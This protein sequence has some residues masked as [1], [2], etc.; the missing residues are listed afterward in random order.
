MLKSVPDELKARLQWVV[1]R[2]ERRDGKP[3]KVPYNP[4]TL[5]RADTTD[6]TTWSDFFTACVAFHSRPFSGLGYVFAA[7]DPYAG[8]DQDDCIDRETGEIASYA[9]ENVRLL[10]SYTEIS[11]SGTGLKT[12][13][14]ATKR[15]PRCTTSKGPKC[16]FYDR[17]RFFAVTGRV[18]AGVSSRVEARDAEYHALYTQT[19][20]DP[21]SV[22]TDT[23]SADAAPD[24]FASLDDAALL[25]LAFAA[26]NGDETRTLYNGSDLTFTSASEADASLLCRLA[27]YTQ[28][29]V[30]QGTAQLERLLRGSQRL[31][32]KWDEPRG[33]TTW[34]AEQIANGV[35]CVT[36]SY[37]PPRRQNQLQQPQNSPKS[38]VAAVANQDIPIAW[39]P[40]ISLQL[41][42]L[43]AFPTDALPGWLGEFV[44]G[45]AATTETAPDVAAMLAL[46]ICALASA[47]VA[48]IAAG[49]SWTEPL[50]LFTVVALPPASRKSAVFAFV[51]APL[52]AYEQRRNT[53]LTPQIA[54]ALTHLD[55]LNQRLKHAREEAVKAK[56]PLE[57]QK[58]EQEAMALTEEVRQFTESLPV[59]LRL[60]ADDCTPEKLVRLM[61]EQGGHMGLLSP[62]GG[63]FDIM[64]GRY[65][66]KGANLDIYLKGHAGDDYHY[67]RVGGGSLTLRA[68]TLTMGLAVQPEVLRGLMEKP[69]FRG[70]GLLG[71]FL[72][73]LPPDNIGYCHNRDIPLPETLAERY[74]AGVH[75]L[76]DLTPEPLGDG[77]TRP[78]LLQMEPE[79]RERFQAYRNVVERE[80]RAGEE[81]GDITDWGGKLRG[82]IARIAGVLHLA[83]TGDVHGAVSLATMENA[84]RIGD[85]LM[86]HGLAAYEEMKTD[87]TL[88]EARRLVD[89]M[90]RKG[91]SRFTKRDV[92]NAHRSRFNTVADL[93]PV[94]CLLRDCHYLQLFDTPRS[95]PG[96]PASPIILVNPALLDPHQNSEE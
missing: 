52:N 33:D 68:P 55:I 51:K 42:T 95:G 35:A 81:L 93:D 76:L 40:L 2:N 24:A 63:V 86:R 72:Y 92:F 48:R 96:Q 47:R 79:A 85:Y 67:D 84:I 7:D 15:G 10:N 14:R 50:N 8:F 71:R 36:E 12:W 73:A 43:P 69:G 75:R 59:L 58:K 45:V 44:T 64:G 39:E 27:F 11:P 18:W 82:A 46:A 57:Q 23:P 22:P 29:V 80:L 28:S 53:L 41:Q 94:L 38:A 66:D 54:R 65:S 5:A 89:W 90:Q 78:W 61:H 30:G 9:A 31:R 49:S 83:A 3:T 4:H 56:S 62:E 91:L 32:P 60:V 77:Q 25:A 26:R 19:F 20:G 37:T 74:A 6:P 21:S 34:L 17:S 70:R 13:V 87:D 88:D 16:E 1:W